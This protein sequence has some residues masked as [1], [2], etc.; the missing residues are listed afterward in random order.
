MTLKELHI[1]SLMYINQILI[2][3]N[4]LVFYAIF[5][6]YKK[7]PVPIFG[8][9]LIYNVFSIFDSIFSIIPTTKDICEVGQYVRLNFS[10]VE[11]M[12]FLLFFYFTERVEKVKKVIKVIIAISFILIIFISFYN[13]LADNFLDKYL[14]VG[15]FVTILPLAIYRLFEIPK[16]S[17]DYKNYSSPEFLITIGIFQFFAVNIN[18]FLLFETIFHYSRNVFI[19][20][21]LIMW[22]SYFVLFVI[23]IIAFNKYSKKLF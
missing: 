14:T 9:F 3:F 10:I 11:W 23:L 20:C 15:E 7:I 17:Q 19:V 4:V 8:L 13:I 1:F 18:L 22:F 16:H 12:V 6:N 5:K 21:A 2:V